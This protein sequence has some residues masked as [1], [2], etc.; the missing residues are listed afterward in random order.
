MKFK[1]VILFRF[2][3][4]YSQPTHT[5]KTYDFY[6]HYQKDSP[7]LTLEIIWWIFQLIWQEKFLIGWTFFCVPIVRLLFLE[8]CKKFELEKYKIHWYFLQDFLSVTKKQINNKYHPYWYKNFCIPKVNDVTKIH[9][10]ASYLS[11][12]F[13]LACIFF[14]VNEGQQFF[15]CLSIL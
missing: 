7:D 4:A 10:T 14:Y 13:R 12:L 9:R 2:W 11:K 5:V 8:T 1:K 15:H 6:F 3:N